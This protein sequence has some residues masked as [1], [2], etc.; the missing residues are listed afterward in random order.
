MASGPYSFTKL[1]EH[2]QR[3]FLLGE[4]GTEKDCDTARV[5]LSNIG[6]QNCS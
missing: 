3:Y 2:E 1:V 4:A 5:P 6:I